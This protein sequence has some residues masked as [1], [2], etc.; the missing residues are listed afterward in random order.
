MFKNRAFWANEASRGII[1]FIFVRINAMIVFIK[2]GKGGDS[3][4]MSR[5]R[6]LMLD[7]L[8]N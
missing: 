5:E 4:S 6:E 8:L 1:D 7:L 3:S 2:M